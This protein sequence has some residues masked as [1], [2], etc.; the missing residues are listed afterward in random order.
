M[1]QKE[2]TAAEK[3]ALKAKRQRK[4][5][6]IRRIKVGTGLCFVLAVVLYLLC[7]L[8]FFK[9]DSVVVLPADSESSTASKYYGDED[10]IKVSGA[11]KGE[12]LVLISKTDI[13]NSVETLLPYI[14]N[15]TVKRSY[16]STLKL[17]VED[18]DAF[19]AVEKNSM[20]TLMNRDFKVL[21]TSEYIPEGCARLVGMNFT[22]MYVGYDAVFEEEAGKTRLNGLIAEC[23][24]AGIGTVTKY[25]LTN[26]ANVRIVI[27]NRIT[28]VLGTLTGLQ[29]K[30]SLGIKTV[31]TELQA[32]PQAHIIIDVTNPERSYVRDDHSPIETNSQPEE[33]SETQ[34]PENEEPDNDA[35]KPEPVG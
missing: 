28:L 32:N 34:I 24:A 16:P 20:F 14:G 1:Q 13:K 27:N 17:I 22:E 26:I 7:A 11:E 18:H 19:F 8:V 12:S 29:D 6:I 5:Q 4:T 30:L 25:D 33:T 21:E 31:E 15:I 35:V 23:E 10:I 9:I 3:K 2:L